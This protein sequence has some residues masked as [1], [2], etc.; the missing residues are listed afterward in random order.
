[1]NLEMLEVI[2]KVRPYSMVDTQGIVFSC[3]SVL[4]LIAN[5]IP[6]AIVECGTWMGGCAFAMAL[7]QREKFGEVVRPIHM[8]DSFEGLPDVD[9]R[10][11]P[12]AQ[13][14]QAHPDDPGYLDNCRA[15]IERVL[16]AR[17]ALGLTETDCPIRKGWFE[18]TV[19]G[20]ES[21]LRAAEGIALLRV[22]C[23]WYASVRFVLDQLAPLVSTRGITILDD[24][25][26]W[27]GAARAT[28]DWL[29]VNQKAYRIRQGAEGLPWAWMR[30]QPARE[31][32]EPL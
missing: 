26:A 3:E 10:D 8:L 23:D 22:D 28:H 16:D 13:H 18:E 27:D 29:S 30:H 21:E 1:M 7:V 12:L 24:Y 32:G 5:D 17:A 14:Y 11:G 15:P 25:Y 6:G 2:E 9:E 4:E 31:A 20:L 19:P